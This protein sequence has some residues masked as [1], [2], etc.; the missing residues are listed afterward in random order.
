MRRLKIEAENH[1]DSVTWISEAKIGVRASLREWE[2]YREE[3]TIKPLA[4]ER[5]MGIWFL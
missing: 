2:E 1:L 3:K 5:V 4:M